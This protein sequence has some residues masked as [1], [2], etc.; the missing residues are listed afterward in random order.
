MINAKSHTIN[1]IKKKP[2]L[3]NSFLI[4]YIAFSMKL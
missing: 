1:L 3:D 2:T 4:P